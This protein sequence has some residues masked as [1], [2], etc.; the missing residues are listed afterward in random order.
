M[1]R[2]IRCPHMFD[3]DIVP[4]EQCGDYDPCAAHEARNNAHRKSSRKP[5]TNPQ[6][7]Q[8]RRERLMY[9]RRERRGL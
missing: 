8:P 9:A 6:G 1:N 5:V 2:S 7:R 4:C 3:R